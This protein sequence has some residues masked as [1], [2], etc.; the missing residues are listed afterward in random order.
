LQVVY[1][2]E[3]DYKILLFLGHTYSIPQGVTG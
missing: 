2:R 3:D 1:H